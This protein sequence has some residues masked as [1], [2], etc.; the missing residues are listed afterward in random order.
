MRRPRST[1][2][3]WRLLVVASLALALTWCG[4]GQKGKV[5]ISNAFISSGTIQTKNVGQAEVDVDEGGILSTK[6]VTGMAT[7]T[8]NVDAPNGTATGTYEGVWADSSGFIFATQGWS[9]NG[10]LPAS[11]VTMV[12][13]PGDPNVA[14]TTINALVEV[15]YPDGTSE[16]MQSPL[17]ANN[18]ITEYPPNF[19]V[20]FSGSNPLFT[21]PTGGAPT[22][23]ALTRMETVAVLTSIYQ[24]TGDF[25]DP[26]A[27]DFTPGANSVVVVEEGDTL[28]L[29]QSGGGGPVVVLAFHVHGTLIANTDVTAKFVGVTGGGSLVLNDSLYDIHLL[30][31]DENCELIIAPGADETIDLGGGAVIRGSQIFDL[32]DE[33]TESGYLSAATFRYKDSLHMRINGP[34]VA[35]WPPPNGTTL[36]LVTASTGIFGQ[37]GS[38]EVAGLGLAQTAKL[39]FTPPGAPTQISLMVSAASV[40]SATAVAWDFGEVL[41]DSNVIPGGGAPVVQYGASQPGTPAVN[42]NNEVVISEEFLANLTGGPLTFGTGIIQVTTPSAQ[43]AAGDVGQAHVPANPAEVMGTDGSPRSVGYTLTNFGKV[44]FNSTNGG[45]SIIR[46]DALKPLDANATTNDM[47]I[48]APGGSIDGLGDFVAQCPHNVTATSNAALAQPFDEEVIAFPATT[49]GGRSGVFKFEKQTNTRT[50]LFTNVSTGGQF[51]NV[52][53]PASSRSGQWA[54]FT[55][56]ETSTTNNVVIAYDL[57]TDTFEVVDDAGTAFVEPFTIVDDA[58]WYYAFE[59]PGTSQEGIRTGQV[60]APTPP[61]TVAFGF[62]VIDRLTADNNGNFVFRGNFFNQPTALFTANVLNQDVSDILRLITVGEITVGDIMDGEQVTDFDIGPRGID[63]NARPVIQVT[64]RQGQNTHHVATTLNFPYLAIRS[65]FV[66]DDAT[67][68]ENVAPPDGADVRIVADQFTLGLDISVPAALTFSVYELEGRAEAP[69]TARLTIEPSASIVA[70][71][72]DLAERVTLI[73]GDNNP[74]PEITAQDAAING[75]IEVGQDPTLVTFTFDAPTFFGG[76]LVVVLDLD[77]NIFT[78]DQIQVEGNLTVAAGAAFDVR[79]ANGGDLIVGQTIPLVTA[80]GAVMG[81]R[82]S[83]VPVDLG[84]GN[85]LVLDDTSMNPIRVKVVAGT[86]GPVSL[87]CPDRTYS[88]IPFNPPGSTLIAESDGA[89]LVYNN[90]N[91]GKGGVTLDLKDQEL[92]DD[93]FK[94]MI[95]VEGLETPPSICDALAGVKINGSPVLAGQTDVRNVG[96][97][98]LCVT[99]TFAQLGASQVRV[100]IC[101][102]GKEVGQVDGITPDGGNSNKIGRLLLGT[103]VTGWGFLGDNANN[104]WGYRLSLGMPTLFTPDNGSPIGPS[105]IGDEIKIIAQGF[106]RSMIDE[107]VNFDISAFNTTFTVTGEQIGDKAMCFGGSSFVS[108]G[109]GDLDTSGGGGGLLFDVNCP[110]GNGGS[111][112]LSKDGFEKSGGDSSGGGLEFNP[113]LNAALFDTTPMADDGIALTATGLFDASGGSSQFTWGTTLTANGATWT[114]ETFGGAAGTVELLRDGVV[115]QSSIS[116]NP[117]VETAGDIAMAVSMTAECD[118]FG[119]QDPPTEQGGT[120]DAGP[121]TEL[122]LDAPADASANGMPPV[123]ADTV[124]FKFDPEVCKYK[125]GDGKVAGGTQV[126]IQK[127]W[128]VAPFR[129]DLSSFFSPRPEGGPEVAGIASLGAV[130]ASGKNAS[131]LMFDEQNRM[132]VTGNT[133]AGGVELFLFDPNNPS[134]VVSTP[135]IKNDLEGATVAN[136]GDAMTCTAYTADPGGSINPVGSAGLF[137]DGTDVRLRADYKTT[138]NVDDLLVTIFGPGGETSMVL[139]GASGVT[140]GFA[141]VTVE[142]EA[143]VP[144]KSIVAQRHDA[145]VSI[146]A[147]LFDS[148]AAANLFPGTEATFLAD[149]IRISPHNFAGTIDNVARVDLDAEQIDFAV[150]NVIVGPPAPGDCDEDGDVD[151]DD[152]IAFEDCATGPDQGPPAPGCEGKDLDADGDIDQ[153]DFGIVQ[154]CVRGAGIQPDPNCAN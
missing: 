43:P 62:D 47:V 134:G 55:A 102:D 69:H 7:T 135:R 54:I 6:T 125:A 127:S 79:V 120:E 119:P 115:V 74:A 84:N 147:I 83:F 99:A 129:V 146:V 45:N 16:Y 103:E 139:P 61:K 26:G 14:D 80:T 44:I 68:R 29:D 116:P 140:T 20:T 21:Q 56:T 46:I 38:V 57:T 151:L 81:A 11:T 71:R 106:D 105:L 98:E 73:G 113:P 104:E 60:G 112:E 33:F 121:M 89:L 88:R 101:R 27:F 95:A 118:D 24:G 131:C 107:V 65:G 1:W 32:P 91:D 15:F 5:F 28:T 51:T 3:R 75:V 148:T 145:A 53:Y 30:A 40:S 122:A 2:K 49:T 41:S 93:G 144:V 96:T 142:G 36:P 97:N 67:Y 124:R 117:S 64:L 130:A 132:F 13:D 150:T 138:L 141:I 8:L 87:F 18:D 19:L 48:C 52:S 35:P 90:G 22:G 111:I 94:A 133:P 59:D 10:D 110:S 17:T 153:D 76:E 152:L 9:I 108:F 23:N 86:A 34:P 72:F 63:P 4:T 100:R 31:V 12:Q 25:F 42:D 70:N 77:G 58:T 78:A 37:P 50:E 39:V 85:A 143:N 82:P 137:H 92:L 66:D 123:Q 109:S 114:I 154:R 128:L 149:E 126:N 136:P